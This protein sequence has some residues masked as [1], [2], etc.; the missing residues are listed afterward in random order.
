MI[1]L[2]I[3]TKAQV[4]KM[5]PL[6]REL[7]I[8]RIPYRF[9]LTGQHEET[10]SDLLDAFEIPGPDDVLVE[11]G[12]SDTKIK[13]FRW[14]Y[15]A[16]K[17]VK[18]REYLKNDTSIILVHGDTM[19]TLF[20]A[21]VGRIYGIPVG[22]VE[23]GLRSFNYFHPFPEELVRIITSRLTKVHY[24][25][26][27]WA[28]NNLSH[29]SH[30][31]I[32]VNTSENTILDSLRFAIQ[33]GIECELDRRYAVVSIHRNENLSNTSRFEH[34]MQIIVSVSKIIPLEFILHPV[35][36]K[37]LFQSGW[38]EKLEKEQNIVIKNRMDYVSFSKLLLHSR[39]LIS[40]GGSNQEEAS[41]MGLP[42][43]LVRGKTERQ[44]GLDDG[45]VISNYDKSL[46]INFVNKHANSEWKLKSLPDIYP[47]EAIVNHLISLKL[48]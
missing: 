47:C 39:L 16:I 3:G 36:E 2:V 17:A 21:L 1:T 25:S 38:K 4:V 14:L 6:M 27:K 11:I 41:L 32:L 24:T 9:V 35:T 28:K 43:L 26:S 40:D 22:H 45:V 8:R 5:A 42:C 18:H 23:A 19:S 48:N 29:L 10:I 46:I 20:G 30:K 15:S 44:E 34:I 33:E 12:E 13:L 31:S 7:L 37:K